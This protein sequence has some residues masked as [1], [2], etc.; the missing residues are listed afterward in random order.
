[1]AKFFSEDFN[2]NASF[3]PLSLEV[4]ADDIDAVV[5]YIE[6]AN[7]IAGAS[8]NDMSFARQVANFCQQTK[9]HL[10]TAKGLS[11]SAIT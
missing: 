2:L 3:A 1:M 5:T 9:G 10:G 11:A 7:R 6:K 8:K 4:S